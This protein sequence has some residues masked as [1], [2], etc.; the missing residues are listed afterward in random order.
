MRGRINRVIQRERFAVALITVES[1]WLT[2]EPFLARG[3]AAPLLSSARLSAGY[4]VSNVLIT[5]VQS[6][7]LA[8]K[9]H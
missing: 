8:S 6:V 4:M 2:M 1:K 5:K 3:L 9:T 7:I